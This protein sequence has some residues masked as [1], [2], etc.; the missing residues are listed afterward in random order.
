MSL[1][2]SEYIVEMVLIGIGILFALL[3]GKKLNCVF[4]ALQGM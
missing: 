1:K 3:L 4:F 2:L